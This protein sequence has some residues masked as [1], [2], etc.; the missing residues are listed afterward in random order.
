MKK[1]KTWSPGRKGK[2][3]QLSQQESWEAELAATGHLWNGE[4]ISGR[5]ALG[6]PDLMSFLIYL[7]IWKKKTLGGMCLWIDCTRKNKNK[8]IDN[9]WWPSSLMDK[10]SVPRAGGCGTSRVAETIKCLPTLWET[11]FNPWVGKIS[12][13]RKWQLTPVVL[14]GKIPWT[15][16]PGRPQWD[17]KELDTTEQLHFLP[18]NR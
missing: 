3:Y 4:G 1:R 14:P 16:K 8:Y 15:D 7:N 9:G 13:R 6:K 5:R 17:R 10:A 11:W 12:W 18:L 2:C